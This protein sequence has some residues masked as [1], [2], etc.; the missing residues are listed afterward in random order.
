MYKSKKEAALGSEDLSNIA[1]SK[2]LDNVLIV[3]TFSSQ[4]DIMSHS[5]PSSTL[6]TVHWSGIIFDKI[7]TL[8]VC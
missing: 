1:Y 7:L 3:L 4:S 5:V 8:H 2:P 6:F